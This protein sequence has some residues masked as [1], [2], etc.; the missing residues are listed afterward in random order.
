MIKKS[1]SGVFK[2]EIETRFTKIL[3]QKQPF[4]EVLNFCLLE[5]YDFG[6]LWRALKLNAKKL[7]IKSPKIEYQFRCVCNYD[8][9]NSPDNFSS[10]LANHTPMD[11]SVYT[12]L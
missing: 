7:D 12:T 6:R 1:A 11:K 10:M 2:H 5:K 8:L 4:Y 9:C 3:K